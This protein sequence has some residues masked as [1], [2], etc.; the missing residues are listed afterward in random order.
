MCRRFKFYDFRR[1]ERR[2]SLGLK[3][4]SWLNLSRD[5]EHSY[6][7]YPLAMAN[8]QV[9]AWRLREKGFDATSRTG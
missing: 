6:W 8:P 9:S 7:T 3:M 4:D 2:R 1:I 5:R